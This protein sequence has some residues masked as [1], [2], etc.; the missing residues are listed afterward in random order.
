MSRIEAEFNSLGLSLSHL[1]GLGV[2]TFFHGH[3]AGS[4]QK[5]APFPC[6][7]C[8]EHPVHSPDGRSGCLDPRCPE[9]LDAEG[10]DAFEFPAPRFP[11]F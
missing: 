4:E 6:L 2:K 10:V 3:V 9:E 5:N 8:I 7:K 1:G 11:R